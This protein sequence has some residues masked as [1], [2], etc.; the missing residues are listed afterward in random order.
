MILNNFLCWWNLHFRATIDGQYIS[1]ECHDPPPSELMGSRQSHHRWSEAG[2]VSVLAWQLWMNR[3]HPRVLW[4]QAQWK[5][6]LIAAG[7]K[8][9]WLC[10]DSSP[11]PF[12]FHQFI[13]KLKITGSPVSGWVRHL[14]RCFTEDMELTG[15]SCCWCLCSF[16]TYL[17]KWKLAIRNFRMFLISLCVL[18][19]NLWWIIAS[20]KAC[21]LFVLCCCCSLCPSL[22]ASF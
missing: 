16:I 4:Y 5:C 18:F 3:V 11:W 6:C 8:C 7:L 13:N 12:Y 10:D 9:C 15:R 22:S 1:V 19:F 2:G 21:F 14:P 20:L 17:R